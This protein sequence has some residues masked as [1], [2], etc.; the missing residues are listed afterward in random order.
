MSYAIRVKNISKKY[1]IYNSEKNRLGQIINPFNKNTQKEFIALNNISFDVNE[2]EILGII[3]S[4]GSGKSTLLKI[5]TGVCFKTSGE[6][7]IKGKV[8]SILE[9]GTGFNNELTGIEN[10]YLNAS[11]MGIGKEEIN[12]IKDDIINFAD[13]GEFI[14]YPI[15]TYSSGMYARLAFAVAIHVNPDILIVDEILSV[16]D[17]EFQNKCMDKFKEFKSLGKTIIY[18]SH[19]LDAVQNY[20]EKAIWLEKGEIKEIGSAIEV[21]EKYYKNILE[22]DNGAES[23]NC[24][25]KLSD[26]LICEKK[27]VYQYNDSITFNIKYEV[28]DEDISTPGITVEMKRAYTKPCEFRHMDQF[29]CSINSNVD[30]FLIPWNLGEN[31]IKLTFKNLMLKGGVYYINIIFSESQNLISLESIENAMSFTINS[32]RKSSGFV[33]LKE[34]W[35]V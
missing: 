3:G 1:K 27:N 4:N 29:I 25:V 26:V 32:E 21:V 9:L 33:F 15:K 2:G 30:D 13:I 28:L 34:E 19:G 16:G 10:I 14:N 22:L 24:F 12:K 17:I 35:R 23:K 31:N 18:V 20:C 7:F 6:L 5:L 8:A 11:I